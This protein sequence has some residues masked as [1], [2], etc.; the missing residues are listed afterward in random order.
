[1]NKS[2]LVVIPGTGDEAEG[3]DT[4]IEPRMTAADVIRATGQN[5]DD[6]QIQI[7]RGD[8]YISLSG[9]DNVHKAMREGEKLFLTPADMTVGI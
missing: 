4:V 5:P 1:M 7:Q 6:F 8:E 2:A 9:Q 3:R